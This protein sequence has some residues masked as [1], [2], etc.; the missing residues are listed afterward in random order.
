MAGK[1]KTPKKESVKSRKMVFG[2]V[3]LEIWIEEIW[4]KMSFLAL[5]PYLTEGHVWTKCVEL[6][7]N[8][9]VVKMVILV[10]KTCPF[11][12]LDTACAK[13]RKRQT[14]GILEKGFPFSAD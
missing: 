12:D 3:L 8:T 2:N 4:S 10:I 5:A 13:D 7:F 6:S 11:Q 9:F 1:I 14:L